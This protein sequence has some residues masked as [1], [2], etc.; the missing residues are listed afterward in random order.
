MN[1][2]KK[3]WVAV[4]LGLGLI[5]L[6]AMGVVQ[7]AFPY[8]AV[9]PQKET[10]E[11][12]VA[13]ASIATTG[14]EGVP[15]VTTVS[16]EPTRPVVTPPSIARGDTIVS[17]NFTGAYAQD[18]TLQARANAEITRLS[19]LLEM[20][21]S[22]KVTL[23]VGIAN[24]YELLG[25]GKQ[26]YEYLSRAIEEGGE[27]TGLPWHNLGVLM[28]RLGALETARTA[29][30]NATIVQSQYKQWHYA[31]LEFLTTRMR[32][33]TADIEKAFSAALKNLGQDSDILD[34]ESAWKQL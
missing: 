32:D 4:G 24:Q 33:E 27:T 10:A 26:E 1:I 28:E 13:D 17:W 29:Y 30:E 3:H 15:A 6:A 2:S 22:S 14:S 31:F 5:T 25:D 20:A 21:T 16:I 23:L 9:A 34:L 18:S 12:P 7:F 8:R 11:S 19:G